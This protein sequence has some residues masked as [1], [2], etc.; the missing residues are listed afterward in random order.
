[1]PATGAHTAVSI[2]IALITT[3]C[4][5]ALTGLPGFTVTSMMEPAMGAPTEPMS[6]VSARS[7]TATFPRVSADLR[8]TTSTHLGGAGEA[9]VVV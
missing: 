4:W 1:M 7:R 8:S 5:P 2:F 3:S 6:V 9:A